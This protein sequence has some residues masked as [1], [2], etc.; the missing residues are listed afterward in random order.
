M[1]IG[2]L[3]A[4]W[5]ITLNLSK[6]HCQKNRTTGVD[7]GVEKIADGIFH[8]HNHFAKQYGVSSKYQTALCDPAILLLGVERKENVNLIEIVPTPFT[9]WC[10]SQ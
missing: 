6:W 4:R 9:F 2:K 5:N 7:K 10:Y 8:W 1:E 3:K